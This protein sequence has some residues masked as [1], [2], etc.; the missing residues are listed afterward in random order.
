MSSPGKE[1]TS[2]NIKEIKDSLNTD[3]I[4]VFADSLYMPD[5]EKL[6]ALAA[7]F[8]KDPETKVFGIYDGFILCGA[9]AVRLE[10]SARTAY[11]RN[12]AVEKKLRGAGFGKRLILHISEVCRGKADIL[13]AETD[14]EAVGFY[15]SVGFESHG[16]CKK[17]GYKRYL[18]SM[19]L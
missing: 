18:C 14:D 8:K 9:A 1:N 11:I 12:I 4:A 19:H 7:E 15:V 2:I 16:I 13:C 5:K 10:S 3:I 6:S 17:S